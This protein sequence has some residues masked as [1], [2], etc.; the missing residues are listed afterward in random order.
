MDYLSL[1][2]I[3]IN[4]VEFLFMLADKQKAR[5]KLWRIPERTLL[6]VAI[7]GGSLGGLLGMQLFRHKTRNPKFAIGL[8]CIFAVQFLLFYLYFSHK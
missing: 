8:P 5:E 1:Y 7:L 3:I 6:A 4:A 2:L